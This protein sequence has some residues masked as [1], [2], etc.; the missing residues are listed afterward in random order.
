MMFHSHLTFLEAAAKESPE[1]L[2]FKCAQFEVEDDEVSHRKIIGWKDVTY[3]KFYED[4]Q[5]CA[6]YWIKTLQA[7]PRSVIGMWWVHHSS[8][9]YLRSN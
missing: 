5:R 9:G 6:K 1:R 3:G 7:P 4:I 2:C 8:D